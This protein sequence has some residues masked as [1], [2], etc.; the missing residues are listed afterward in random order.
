MKTRSCLSWALL[1]AL[2]LLAGCQRLDLEKTL[3]VAVGEVH[4]VYID[5]PRSDQKVTARINSPGAPVSAY[6]VLESDSEAAQKKMMDHQAPAAP[7]AGKDKAEDI[8]LEATVPAKKGY[9]LLLRADAKDA[10]VKVKVT[11]R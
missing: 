8:T 11:G 3:H 4:R 9:A 2:F 10:D 1:A 5:P 6:L 7:L